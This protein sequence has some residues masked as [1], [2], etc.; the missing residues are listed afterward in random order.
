[1]KRSLEAVSSASASPWAR[2]EAIA[3]ATA[4]H[5][6]VDA[7][8]QGCGGNGGGSG[9]TPAAAA[10]ASP[11]SLRI[12]R[13]ADEWRTFSIVGQ[14]PVVHIELAKRNQLLLI[15]PLCANTLAAAALGLCGNLL[16]SVL[17]AWYYDLDAAFATPLAERYGAHAVDKPVL[18]A[19]AM[20]TF[21]WHQRVTG[22]HLAVLEARGVRV[23]PP[24]AKKLACGDTGV[25]AMAE[26]PQVVQAAVEALRKH[27]QA[28]EQA[29]REAARAEAAKTAGNAAFTAKN[30]DEAIKFFTEAI[31][32]DP[33][34]HVLY[35]NRSGAY[36]AK[37]DFKAALLDA[38]ECIK[39]NEQF[40]KG[41]SRRGAAYFGLKNWPQSQA[42]Y[43]RG[44]ELDPNSAAMKAELEKRFPGDRG[45]FPSSGSCGPPTN[46][47]A[48]SASTALGGFA[49]VSGFLY[50]LPL[51]PRYAIPMYRG[52]VI[53]LLLLSMLH[54]VSAFELK[55][56][57][58]VEPKFKAAQ[59]SQGLMLLFMLLI[60]PPVPFAL[61]PFLALALLH[62]VHAVKEPAQKLPG[63]LSTFVGSRVAQLCTPEGQFQ[64]A[65]FG[66][67]SEVI[68]AVMTPVLCLVQGFRAAL[69]GFFFFQYVV[70]RSRSNEMTMKALELLTERSDSVFRHRYVPA[71]LQIV[72]S[73][74]KK[75]IGR[76]ST[77]TFFQ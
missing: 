69:L 60:L 11:P 32:A 56:S 74:A 61:M 55:F 41:H 39:L 8:D 75:F 50:M 13:D 10:T 20:N 65:S 54:L 43:E 9:A 22:S 2:L 53:C 72:Y 3:A 47:T 40:A 12:F 37:A 14:D 28:Q 52:C 4:L 42:A 34:N 36:C 62:S 76:A 38:N 26:V 17:R 21:M 44:L 23:V 68:L 67:V 58:L 31:E 59:E 18:V 46:P 64:I 16:G 30:Y 5:G 48:K 15:A 1:M 71:P 45:G 35:S 29:V 57:T 51:F 6:G 66:A 73:N 33:T 19:P 70:R 77:S 7:N 49:L 25:G 27:T 63:P 24:V